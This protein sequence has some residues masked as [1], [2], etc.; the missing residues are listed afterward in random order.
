MVAYFFFLRNLISKNLSNTVAE[1]L[2][3]K[4][5]G[6]FKSGLCEFV[7]IEMQLSFA[8]N[9]MQIFAAREAGR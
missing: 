2:T 6:N 5:I 4:V 7:Y 9:L 3:A 1:M 8:L